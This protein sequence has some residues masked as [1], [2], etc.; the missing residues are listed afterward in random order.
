MDTDNNKR[1]TRLQQLGGSDFEIVEGQADI[2][3]WKVRDAAGEKLGKV[4][5]LIFD[6]ESRKVRYLVIALEDEKMEPNSRDVLVPIGIAEL[7]ADTEEV[8]LPGV[9]IEQLAALPEYAAER[10]DPAYEAS[11]HNVFGG[12]GAPNTTDSFPEFYNHDHF[13]DQHLYR[14]RYRETNSDQ[15]STLLGQSPITN[16]PEA[17]GYIRLRS[18]H[19]DNTKSAAD[20]NPDNT[21]PIEDEE[22]PGPDDGH[23]G[24]F[25]KI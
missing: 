6:Y 25:P 3:G 15:T 4:T 22:V 13:N 1:N 24:A 17:G 20:L 8:L 14:N 23:P 18:Q 10:F 5:E 9:T 19:P 16:L 21:T 12:L 7:P 11:V 2:R